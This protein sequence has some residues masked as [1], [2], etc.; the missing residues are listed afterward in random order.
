MAES[1]G[2]RFQKWIDMGEKLNLRGEKLMDFVE[3]QLEKER[4][5]EIQIQRE[6]KEREI[7]IQREEKEREIQIQREE[8]E[9]EIQ[10]QREGGKRKRDS[11]S[12]GGKRKRDSDSKGGKRKR[13]SDSK[14]GKRKRG[15][16]GG[17][18]KGKGVSVT[19]GGKRQGI[20]E[21]AYDHSTQANLNVTQ[22]V[23]LKM[24]YFDER[25]DDL[26]TYLTRFE[27]LARVQ[28]WEEDTWG[29]RLG[30]LLRGKALEVY[31]GLVDDEATSYEALT[32][33]LRAHFR[34]TPERYRE[35][36]RNSKRLEGE[37]F[38]QFVV[39][40]E[41][42]LK[43]W[44]TLSEKKE[45]FEDLKE[46]MREQQ[47]DPLLER[48][49]GLATKGEQSS[50]GRKG[51]VTFFWKK[52]VLSRSFQS[53]STKYER[54]VV[55]S[56]LRRQVM[57][58]AHDS[59]MAG[60]MGVKR[61]LDRVQRNF[62]W[63]G[64]NG[65]VRRFVSS[66]D[67]CQRVFPRGKVKMT[68]GKMPLIGEPFRRVGVD[69][70]GPIVPASEGGH[71]YL[72][73]MVDFAT[74]YPEAVAFRSVEAESVAE[75]L[76]EMWT[77]VGV[78]K[79]MLTDRGSQFVGGVMSQVRELL[80]VK[81]LVTTPYHAQ[82]NGLVERMN[83]TLKTMLRLRRFTSEG[84]STCSN[85]CVYVVGRYNQSRGLTVNL[86]RGT[87]SDVCVYVEG[88][89][90]VRR[91]TLQPVVWTDLSCVVGRVQTLVYMS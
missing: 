68:L 72:L 69:L 83:G 36:L 5:R 41:T 56:K 53:G 7:Q 54:V 2:E 79:E 63:P 33:A 70:V 29:I 37:T 45:T 60:H 61:T 73:V 21:G 91:E 32:N 9:R 64:V 77:R 55:P 28:K 57:S 84:L 22:A 31:N 18:R 78:P 8:K 75:G 49:S 52:G 50:A 39:R 26:D 44:L 88:R 12:K 71:R 86:R 43:R 19:K 4:E 38:Q 17:K 87:C 58:L 47:S 15:P 10:I 80:N 3:R 85:A 82:C 23:K 13:D 20:S 48:I 25:H 42:F 67:A 6:E 1:E 89:L 16:E 90:C 30:T 62:C 46:L 34:L 76:I 11:D 59:A 66:C 51:R 81:G 74:R 14:G 65:D 35:K 24:P 27:R 40:L